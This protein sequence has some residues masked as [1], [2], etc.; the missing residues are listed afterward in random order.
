MII[1][2]LAQSP[3]NYTSCTYASG[4]ALR[5][6]PRSH[7]LFKSASSPLYLQGV[8]KSKT[9]VQLTNRSKLNHVCSEYSW[10]CNEG[11]VSAFRSNYGI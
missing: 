8:L 10:D 1:S 2:L 9:F 5:F 3:Y 4:E 6:I 11:L 7:S